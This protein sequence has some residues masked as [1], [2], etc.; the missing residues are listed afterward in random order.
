MQII[1][2]TKINQTQKDKCSFICRIHEL[3]VCV[4]YETRKWIKRVEDI[5]LRGQGKSDGRSWRDDSALRAFAVPVE[6]LSSFLSIQ[7]G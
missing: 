2:L 3:C 4:C 6:H 1:K 7:D 5:V